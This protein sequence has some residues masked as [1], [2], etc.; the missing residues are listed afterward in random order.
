[1]STPQIHDAV[2]RVV[3][4]KCRPTTGRTLAH[5]D[6]GA[7]RGDLIRRM[8]TGLP[9]ISAACDYQV[10]RF[11]LPAVPIRRVDLN[12]EPLP[13]PDGG[14]EIVTCC[15]VVEHLESYRGLVR[16][17]H[18]V[19]KPGGLLVITTPNVLNARSRVRYLVSGFANLFGPL[20]LQND[21]RYSTGGHISPIPYF[22]LVHGLLESGFADV[23]LA[24]DKVQKTSVGWL[25]LLA[26]LIGLGWL[27]F[28]R[29]EARM[30]STL[31]SENRPHVAT[32]VSWRALVG[33]TIVVSCR[34]PP[35]EASAP[36]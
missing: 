5:L 26:P 27:Q 9:V 4:R 7:G 16:D 19:L 1:M 12:R 3:E 10:E 32:H 13:Y 28:S 33:R 22:Y 23:D 18:R 25:L 17:A 2:M 6:I 30:L 34:K 11:R 8:Q 14:F 29:R 24:I 15:E 36:R 31:T 20:P 35:D 21:R